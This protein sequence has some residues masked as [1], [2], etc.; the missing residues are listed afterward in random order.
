MPDLW[1]LRILT[2]VAEHGSFSAAADTL[3]LSQP[4]VS[5]QIANL[6]REVG[7][8]LFRRVARGVAPTPAGVAAIDLARGVLAR[9]DAFEATMRTYATVDGGSLR[10]CGTPSANTSLVPDAIR[11]LGDQHPDV[12]VSLRQVDPFEVLDAVRDGRVDLALVTEWQLV[13]D[14]PWRARLDPE[15][16]PLSAEDVADLDLVPVL[17]EQMLLALP[18]DHPLAA[19]DP[20]DPVDLVDLRDDTWID[21]AHPDCLGPLYR[22]TSAIGDPPRVGF[23]CDDWAG[24]QAL[25]A[26]GAGVMVVPTLAVPAMRSGIVVRPT[27]P[28]LE[29]RRLYAVAP[30]PPY[31]SPQAAAMVDILRAQ[32]A[33]HEGA[34]ISP[35]S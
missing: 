28:T 25:V 9:V 18:A 14:D 26:G 5:R 12:T 23:V 16:T 22:L 4:A 27:S 8:P 17:D 7:V 15:F 20:T 10:M 24:K 21:G 31:R 1:S 11:A 6:E 19:A 35:R 34:A 29:A 33:A 30:R 2:T 13:D 32:A 3:V